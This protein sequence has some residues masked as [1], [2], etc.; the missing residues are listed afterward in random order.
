MGKKSKFN[1]WIKVHATND[2]GCCTT[3]MMFKSKESVEKA[4]ST[5]GV[6]NGA[7]IMDDAGDVHNS[8]DTFYGFSVVEEEQKGKGLGYLADLMRKRLS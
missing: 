4:F 2:C 1:G 7:T 6:T 5:V 8:I 3:D